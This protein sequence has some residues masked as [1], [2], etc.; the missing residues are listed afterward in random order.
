MAVRTVLLFVVRGFL[1]FELTANLKRI[2]EHF[3]ARSELLTPLGKS[4]SVAAV[5]HEIHVAEVMQQATAL[6]APPA[7][8][9]TS[10]ALEAHGL[11]PLLETSPRTPS[12]AN[13]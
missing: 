4:C 1:K 8:G 10:G 12:F 13:P 3:L 11:P 2:Q 5:G 9:I 6:Q 7:P